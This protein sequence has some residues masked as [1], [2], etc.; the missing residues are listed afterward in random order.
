[1]ILIFDLF[2]FI[3][4]FSKLYIFCAI[5]MTAQLLSNLLWSKLTLKMS[6]KSIIVNLSYENE[7]GIDKQRFLKLTFL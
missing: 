3:A 7:E 2:L 5:T 4:V 1:M 6:H